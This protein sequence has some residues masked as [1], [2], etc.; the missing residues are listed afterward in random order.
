[1]AHETL[2]AKLVVNAILIF[3]QIW[4]GRIASC[5]CKFDSRYGLEWTSL[6]VSSPGMH[7]HERH[8]HIASVSVLRTIRQ[9]KPLYLTPASHQGFRSALWSITEEIVVALTSSPVFTY[10]V[11]SPSN[12]GPRLTLSVCLSSKFYAFA[13]PDS[14]EVKGHGT[15]DLGIRG[16]LEPS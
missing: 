6:C 10:Y 1:M 7:I 14:T 11:L 9:P 5:D 12:R 3:V 15:Y 13:N 2:K 8:A 4:C 16:M